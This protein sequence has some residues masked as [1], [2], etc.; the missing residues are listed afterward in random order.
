M[1]LEYDLLKE[2]PPSLLRNRLVLL[3]HFSDIFCPG[4]AAF[5]LGLQGADE[6]DRHPDRM[7]LDKLR[8]LLVSTAKEAA[9]RKVVQATMVRDRQHGPIVE[10]NR[11]SVRKPVAAASTA[12]SAPT[13]GARSKANNEGATVGGAAGGKTVFAQMVS[14][15]E[16]LGSESLLL[17]HRVWKVKFVGERAD[18]SDTNH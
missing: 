14:R 12:T 11:F 3:H 16:T 8:T 18:R 5:P 17:P 9:F 13:G 15:M 2:M 6:H 4:I 10:L 1:P 7:G